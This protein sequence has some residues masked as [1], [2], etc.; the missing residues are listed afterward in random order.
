[1]QNWVKLVGEVIKAEYPEFDDIL[2]FVCFNLPTSEGRRPETAAAAL[3]SQCQIQERHLRLLAKIA[4]VDAERLATQLAE[5]RVVAQKT[6][7][8][9]GGSVRGAWQSAFQETQRDPR[10]QQ[11]FLVD[12]LQPALAMYLAWPG[13]TSR[14][15]QDFGR[16]KRLLG[17]QAHPET[18][19]LLRRAALATTAG[20]SA[21]QDDI[22]VAQARIIWSTHFRPPRRP[23]TNLR[24]P[25]TTT[26]GDTEVPRTGKLGKGEAGWQQ[27]RRHQVTAQARRPRTADETMAA[28]AAARLAPTLWT[29]NHQKEVDFNRQKLHMA[30]AEKH[31][32][33]QLLPEDAPPGD[34]HFRAVAQGR[35]Q[36]YI[37][38]QR[39]KAAIFALPI[40]PLS[41]GTCVFISKAAEPHLPAA[42]MLSTALRERQLRRVFNPQEAG[43]WVVSDVA[44]APK[45]I[46]W[47]AV[48]LGGFVGTPELLQQGPG[49]PCVKYKAALDFTRIIWVSAAWKHTFQKMYDAMRS[50]A[51]NRAGPQRWRFV[52][53]WDDWHAL[54]V[55]KAGVQHEAEVVAVV[56]PSERGAKNNTSELQRSLG[57][58][59]CQAEQFVQM[60][61]RHKMSEDNFLCNLTRI[62]RGG[63]RQGIGPR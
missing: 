15:E 18:D 13:S 62:E 26:D 55:Q 8:Q 25:K 24:Q 35:Q 61:A 63:T 21:G 44:A 20:Q 16:M 58:Q 57:I 40:S 34:D 6:L 42:S 47:C 43:V 53:R 37:A 12:A 19:H 49:G 52:A 31:M 38:E 9:T 29:S 32:L 1:M 28:T 45:R 36:R 23:H 11:R 46:L 5:H 50:M 30:R 17:E 41:P 48:L 33:G 7:I 2:G 3:R 59:R 54:L 14:L 60:G 10:R 22:L 4:K 27:Q 51:E 56:L 39:R